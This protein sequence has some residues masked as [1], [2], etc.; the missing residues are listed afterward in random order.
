[1]KNYNREEILKTQ[2]LINRMDPVDIAEKLE[3][4][5]KEDLA[6]WIKLLNKDLL[7]DAFSLLPRDKKIEVMGS[8][9]QEKIASLMQDLEEDEVVDTLQEL[10]ANMVRKLM[11]H[12]IDEDRRP[13]I[14]QLLGYQRKSVGSIM[15]VGFIFVKKTTSPTE[16]LEKI[17]HSDL[18]ADRLEQVWVTNESLV[19]IGY[20]NLADLLR[21]KNK[22]IEEFMHQINSSVYAT[23]D[24]EVVAKLAQKYDLSEIPVTDSEGRLVGIVP[25]EWAIDIMHDEYEEDLA[26]IHGISESTPEHYWQGLLHIHRA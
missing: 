18:D 3:D 25:V 6:I 10:P 12:Y 11:N 5:P 13:V 7:A 17:I 24:Q 2:D 20:V 26:N 4:L 8:L 19:L 22:R 14:N 9:S 23:D 1:M 21:N 15:S 16:A